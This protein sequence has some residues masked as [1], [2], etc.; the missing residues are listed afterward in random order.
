MEHI[1]VIGNTHHNT[2]GMV[3]CIGKIDLLCDLILVDSVPSYIAKSRY[4]KSTHYLST[5]NE[6][7]DFLMSKYRDEKSKCIILCCTDTVESILDMNYEKLKDYFYFFNAGEVGKVTSFMNK[8]TQ[9]DLAKSVGISVPFSIEYNGNIND[10]I[11]PC[12][13]KPIQSICGGKHIESCNDTKTL[14]NALRNF[15]ST[16]KIL[17]QQR[18]NKQSEI[19]ILGVSVNGSVIIPGYILKHRDFNGGTLY[20]SVCA[21]EELPKNLVMKCKELISIMHYEGLFGIEFIKDKNDFYFIEINLRNDATTY[22]MAIA[23]V[24][25]PEIYITSLQGKSNVAIRIKRNI[26]AIVDF[27]DLKHK[28]G[29]G[30]TTIQWLRQY[31]NAQC[32]YYWDWKDPI[33]FF[34]APLKNKM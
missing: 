20:S 25:L 17:I 28:K 15:S 19:V 6:I 27:N 5:E 13:I 21:I 2:L 31:I 24:N 10:V 23:G 3:R 8:Q 18:I 34:Y 14:K 26:K 33:P 1:I 32:K 30:I 29:F 16:D 9:I 4:V 12:I 22:A 7:I 11:F